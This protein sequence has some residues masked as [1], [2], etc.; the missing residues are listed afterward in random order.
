MRVNRLE[1]TDFRNYHRAT[2]EFPAGPTLLVG[3]NGMGK[4]N[5][6]EAVVC[7]STGGSHRVPGHQPMIRAGEET[8]II[9]STLMG[10]ERSIDVDVQLN[11]SSPNRAQVNTQ[12]V[13]FRD[14]PRYL[15]TVLFSPEDLAI[16]RAEPTGRRRFLDDILVAATP[17]F[18]SV[19]ADYDKVVRQRN[20]LLK[21]A[22]ASRIPPSELATLDVWDQRLA[23]LG[24]E[25]VQARRALVTAIAPHVATAYRNVAG[26]EH[27][28]ALHYESTVPEEFSAF[29][30]LL[31]A[32]RQ[33]ELDRGTTLIGPHRDDLGL[34]LN[35]LLARHY[36]SHG[37]SWSF[38]L[39]LKLGSAELLRGE[40]TGDP[41]VILDD[42][43]AELDARRR[44]R[45]AESVIGYE[46]VIITA[47]VEDD[48]PSVLRAQ[49][50]RIERGTVVDVAAT[51]SPIEKE[52]TAGSGQSSVDEVTERAESDDD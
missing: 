28:T 52:H 7:L 12:A 1:L 17:R 13:R 48:V 42:V 32:R 29:E 19:L 45:L 35:G 51:D 33:D 3:R 20:S 46:Q 38:A 6:A 34:E 41:V 9:R 44:E 24:F 39:A 43:F 18:T 16:V 47:A 25:I 30:E 14:L 22:R 40:T 27:S 2:V 10:G 5:L 8:A 4:T 31:V 15:K 50:I 26:D 11:R 49:P 36:A 23:Q 21:S 37:E